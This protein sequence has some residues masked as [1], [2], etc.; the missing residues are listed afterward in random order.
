[1]AGKNETTKTIKWDGDTWRVLGRGAV[2]DDGAA[3]CHL[4]SATRCVRQ[5]N[6][7]RPVQINDWIPAAVLE[8]KPTSCSCGRCIA[9]V[10]RNPLF[11][12][13]EG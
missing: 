7:T 3:F 6:G 10:P 12:S 9:C 11:P 8:A 4:A 1:M 13:T 5:R 2:R